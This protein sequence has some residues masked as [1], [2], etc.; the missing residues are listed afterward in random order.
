MLVQVQSRAPYLLKGLK[1]EDFFRKRPDIFIIILFIFYLYSY[2]GHKHQVA[3]L[4]TALEAI[5]FLFMLKNIIFP[6]K[7]F[8]KKW[9]KG[10]KEVKFETTEETLRVVFGFLVFAYTTYR[11]VGI[12]LIESK[13]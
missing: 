13:N 11:A 8:Y 9:V 4:F 1:M 12:L 6:S 10:L 7:T 5:V 2:H 3:A